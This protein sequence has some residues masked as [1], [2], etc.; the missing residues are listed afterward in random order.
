M[1]L[2]PSQIQWLLAQPDDVLS[3]EAVNRQFLQAEHA[4]FDANKVP[5]PVHPDVIQHQLTKKLG[6]FID[7]IVD[8]MRA[9]LEDCWGDDTEAWRE[10][11]VYDT[12]LRVVA[13]LSVRVLM[14]FPLCRDEAFLSICA[15]FIRKVAVAAAGIG[16]F[17]DFLKP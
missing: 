2:P 3:Q 12:M 13:R 14:G 17:P 8:E 6:G 16:L 15:D 11:K 1:I 10:V 7:E 5:D 4:F 9:G